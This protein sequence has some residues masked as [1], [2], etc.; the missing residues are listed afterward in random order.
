MSKIER[1][2]EKLKELDLV[3]FVVGSG[4]AHQSEYVHECDMRRAY[5]TE[6]TGS[7]GTALTVNVDKLRNGY[8]WTDGR[9]FLQASQQL[10]P[11]WELMKSGEPNVLEINDWIIANLSSDSRVGV[12]PRLISASQALSMQKQFQPYGIVLVAAS[13][14]PVDIVWGADRPA[15]PKKP[16]NVH[17]LELAGVSHNDKILSVQNELAK[18][19]SSAFI[20]TMLDEIAWLLNIRGSDVSYNPVIISYAVVTATDCHYFVNKDKLSPTIESHLA[21]AGVI[22]HD[23]AG[24]DSFL[25]SFITSNAGNVLVDLSQINWHI[26]ELVK[27]R[28]HAAVSPIT[29]MKA[30]KNEAESKGIRESHIRDGVALT[31]FLHHLENTIKNTTTSHPYTEYDLAIEL[32]TFRSR[33]PLHVSPSFGTIAGYGANG[34]II[35]YKPEEKTAAV[36]GTDSMLLLDSG[37]QYKDGTTDVTR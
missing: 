3:A 37:A 18:T 15:A 36:V 7:S 28:V 22:I 1:V 2:L 24:I 25:T 34:A 33:M 14:N 32:E 21:S 26:Y 30:L 9:Y 5:L 8:L 31:A 20:V 35:H 4:D 13:V 19:K 27:D 11:E 16:I 10:S 6:F 17:S 29:L 23:Y 12:D